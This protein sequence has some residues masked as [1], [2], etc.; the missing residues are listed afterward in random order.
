M[1]GAYVIF[2]VVLVGLAVCLLGF[3]MGDKAPKRAQP[4][5][6]PKTKG[7]RSR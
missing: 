3:L 2:V 6:P 5:Q 7:P 1:L 4:N